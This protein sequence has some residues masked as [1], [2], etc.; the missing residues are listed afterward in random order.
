MTYY[1]LINVWIKQFYLY[2]VH[3]NEMFLI[4]INVLQSIKVY[5]IK[6]ELTCNTNQFYFT[7]RHMIIIIENTEEEDR[8]IKWN[9]V[10][11]PITADN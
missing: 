4:P 9:K 3:T 5:V 7:F 11:N 1:T 6:D 10:A 2:L 8:I